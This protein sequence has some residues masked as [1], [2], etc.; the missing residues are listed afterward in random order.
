MSQRRRYFFLLFVA[1]LLGSAM[2]TLARAPRAMNR[3]A[4]LTATPHAVLRSDPAG[5][6]SSHP[7]E[8]PPGKDGECQNV[9]ACCPPATTINKLVCGG[10]GTSNAQRDGQGNQEKHGRWGPLE[11]LTLALV[12]LTAVLALFTGLLVVVGWFQRQTME[13][14]QAQTRALERPWVIAELTSDNVFEVLKNKYPLEGDQP[15]GNPLLRLTVE[16]SIKN[17]GRTPAWVVRTSAQFRPIEKA[18]LNGMQPFLSID[19]GAE[20]PLPPNGATGINRMYRCRPMGSWEWQGF[21]K[22]DVCLVFF[23]MIEFRDIWGGID[24]M[25]FSWIWE[26]EYPLPLVRRQPGPQ[27]WIRAT[28]KPGDA[29]AK[30]LSEQEPVEAPTEPA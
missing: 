16:M 2:P 11:Y 3:P 25:W 28:T 18:R 21:E 29:R 1:L 22:G 20:M 19:D 7:Q 8:G 24:E 27:G 4:T 26:M 14:Q 12:G 9:Q 6:P 13:A 5:I 23:G 30:R 17:Y 15:T 10:T